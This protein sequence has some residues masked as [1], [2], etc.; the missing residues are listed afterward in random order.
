M[1]MA[2]RGTSRRQFWL[3]HIEACAESGGSTK[4][5]A[6]AHGLAAASLYAARSRYKQARPRVEGS[7]RGN[8]GG[9]L[10]RA[11]RFVRVE[12]SRCSGSE[13]IQCRVRLSNGA[14]LEL[15]VDAS[16]LETT[17]RAIATVT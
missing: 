14:M 13:R 12:P 9:E 1:S 15:S 8:G 10:R 4:R 16:D 6:E 11:A 5:Y 3:A 17:L 7:T 2:S